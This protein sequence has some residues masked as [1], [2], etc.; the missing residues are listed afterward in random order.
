MLL[1]GMITSLL[2]PQSVHAEVTICR[3]DPRVWLSN[4]KTVTLIASSNDA[5][6]DVKS[7]TY[8]LHAPVG[9]TVTRVVYTGFRFTGKETLRFFADKVTG[10]YTTDTVVTTGSSG[11]PVTAATSIPSVGVGAASGYANQDLIV[12]L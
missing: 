3:T 1:A 4:G 12:N 5:A 2:V 8:T 7:I 9:T 10:R 6:G 11:I